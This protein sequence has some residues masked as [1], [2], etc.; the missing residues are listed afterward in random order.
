VPGIPVL[1]PADTPPDS[2]VEALVGALTRAK[3]KGECSVCRHNEWVPFHGLVR[4]PEVL[5][6]RGGMPA[7]AIA[8]QHCGNVRFHVADVLE[9]YL[10]PNLPG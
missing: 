8:C 1:V 9:R 3:A 4:I 10:D 7:L 6:G 5:D 2:Q